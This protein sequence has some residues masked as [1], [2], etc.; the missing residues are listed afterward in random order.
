MEALTRLKKRED[1]VVTKPDKGSGIVIMDKSEYLRLVSASLI[2][3]VTKFAR[4]DFKPPNL[5]GRPPKHCHTPS[6]RER[7]ALNPASNTA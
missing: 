5:R 3:D 6:E 7:C 4:V 1:I 2:H